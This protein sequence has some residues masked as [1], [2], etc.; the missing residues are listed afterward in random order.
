MRFQ[1]LALVAAVM[2]TASCSRSGRGRN[3]TSIVL[4][5]IDTLRADALG[6]YGEQRPTSPHLDAFARESVRFSR[7]ISQDGVTSPSHASIFTSLYPMVHKVRNSDLGLGNGLDD[8]G[9][10]IE[11]FRLDRKIPTIASVLRCFAQVRR[12]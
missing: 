9:T 3:G 5:S 4:I 7:A 6:C 10:A 1:R 12:R 11:T 2:V 8:T